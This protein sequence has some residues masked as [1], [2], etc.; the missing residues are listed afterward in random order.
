MEG[1]LTLLKIPRKGKG[2]RGDG[3]I[4]EG[5]GGIL[6]MGDSVGKGGCC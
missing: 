4:P 3:K 5:L 1:G 2:E 6:R